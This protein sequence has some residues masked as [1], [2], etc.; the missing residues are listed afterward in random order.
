MNAIKVEKSKLEKSKILLVDDNPSNLVVL[1]EHLKR[2]GFIISVGLDGEETIELAQ[3]IAP[4]LIMLDVSMQPGIDGFETCRRLKQNT[5]SKDIPVIFMSAMFDT[6]YKLKGFKV[7]GVDYITKPFQTEEVLARVCT[8]LALRRQ[9]EQLEK[10]NE[11]LLRKNKL[12]IEQ[13]QQLKRLATTDSLTKLSNRRDFLARTQDEIN[14]CKRNNK[15]FTIILAD[16]D[17]FKRFNDKYGHDCGDFV[18]ATLADL[19]KSTLRKQDHIAR[20]GGEEFVI[21]LPETNLAGAKIV[22]KKLCQCIANKIY[23]YQGLTLS[24]TVTFG[25]SIYNNLMDINTCIKNA[26]NAL[27]KG[28]KAGRNCVVVENIP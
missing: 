10:Q 18:L 20:W 11:E 22:A 3:N 23:N 6:V 17:Y 2:H 19:I 5:F 26:D 28:K 13:A 16:I 25:V 1:I 8:H 24:I 27:Y 4:D 12:I 14:R 15:P 21:R 7:G 9:Q